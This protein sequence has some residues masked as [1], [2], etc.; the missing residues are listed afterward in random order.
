MAALHKIKAD[1][2]N[3]AGRINS[4][5]AEFHILD[6]KGQVWKFTRKGEEKGDNTEYTSTKDNSPEGMAAASGVSVDQVKKD[7]E[8]GKTN[9]NVFKDDGAY[10]AAM[11]GGS[12]LDTEGGV[13]DKAKAVPGPG[14]VGSPGGPTVPGAAKFG[15]MSLDEARAALPNLQGNIRVYIK[16]PDAPATPAA[17][18]ASARD[19]GWEAAGLNKGVAGTEPSDAAFAELAAYGMSEDRDIPEFKAFLAARQYD[20]TKALRDLEK[21]VDW[22]GKFKAEKTKDAIARQWMNKYLGGTE[23][24]AKKAKDLK[25][26]SP[27][28]MQKSEVLTDNPQVRSNSEP[29]D[30]TDE[31]Y[32]NRTGRFAP[33]VRGP[34]AGGAGVYNYGKDP[35]P[36]ERHGSGGLYPT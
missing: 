1:N 15:W 9:P 7:Q 33:V 11:T 21:G 34:G 30:E 26:D 2:P 23:D 17:Q 10:G 12:V 3:A 28:A 18:P 6:N 27:G 35:H 19:V 16:D 20:K 32:Y 13:L 22:D 31:E 29:T 14:E 25:G 5:M 4:G 36:T 24:Y 8:L